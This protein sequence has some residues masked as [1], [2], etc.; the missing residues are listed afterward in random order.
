MTPAIAS[1]NEPR[2]S[3]DEEL[4]RIQKSAGILEIFFHPRHQVRS[5]LQM[6]TMHCAILF[7]AFNHRLPHLT[8]LIL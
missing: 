6:T 3:V 4:C 8:H 2:Y 7:V 5:W 1:E